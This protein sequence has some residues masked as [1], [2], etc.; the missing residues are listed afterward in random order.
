MEE[1][2]VTKLVIAFLAL[3]LIVCVAII[4]TLV[5]RDVAIR[6]VALPENRKM[7]NSTSSEAVVDSKYAVTTLTKE[8]ADAVRSEAKTACEKNELTPEEE[9]LCAGG[10]LAYYM[11]KAMLNKDVKICTLIDDM[12]KQ[13]ICIDGI[14]RR[15]A[16]ENIDE[17]YCF[18][19]SDAQA[20]ISCASEIYYYKAKNDPSNAKT[21]CGRIKDRAFSLKCVKDFVK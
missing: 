21:L 17:N 18:Q 10:N 19:L 14:L 7:T 9:Q 6:R 15:L 13:Q 12:R 5:S 3:G 8:E 20:A 11:N 1:K 4:F 16:I 2:N